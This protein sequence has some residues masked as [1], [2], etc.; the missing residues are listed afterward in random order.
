MTISNFVNEC[1]KQNLVILAVHPPVMAEAL[2]NNEDII[3]T[4][5][6]ILSL[7]PKISIDKISEILSPS[8]I[9]RMIP[10][11]TSYFNKG[12]NAVDFH[13][14]FTVKEKEEFINILSVLGQSFEVEE[15]K[16]E[17]YAIVSAMLP[18]YFW[19]QWKKS[20]KNPAFQK[21]KAQTQYIQL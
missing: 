3:N 20:Q 21:A 10:N 7:A 6:V 16:L 2:K 14:S 8:K 9:I 5:S 11:A 12:Y 13:N 17:G 15:H 18:P 19:F 4:E 1:A